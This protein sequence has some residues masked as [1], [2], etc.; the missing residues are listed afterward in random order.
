MPATESQDFYGRWSS[1]YDVLSHATPGI[2]RLRASALSALDLP[3]DA[4]VLDLGCGAGANIPHL[5]RA[6]GP[7]GRVVGVDFTEPVLARARAR[8]DHDNVQ[9]VRADVTDPPIDGPVDAVVASFLGGMLPDPVATVDAWAS[10][11]RP[12]GAIALLDAS[13]SDARVAWPINQLLKA[14]IFASAPDKTRALR[15]APWTTVTQRVELAHAEIHVHA[16]ETTEY[17][18]LLGSLR[19]T[20]GVRD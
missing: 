4:T 6:V 18:W 12:G 20:M 9:F 17:T 2:R 1:V 5:R 7:A 15:P 14:V 8:H 16:R 10:L 3:D 19:F 13:L 11:V